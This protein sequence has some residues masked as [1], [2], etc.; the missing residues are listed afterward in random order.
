VADE[1]QRCQMRDIEKNNLKSADLGLNL[2]L[3]VTPQAI[4]AVISSSLKSSSYC[5]MATK[6]PT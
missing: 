4:G 3:V 5:A 2:V 6:K 1:F